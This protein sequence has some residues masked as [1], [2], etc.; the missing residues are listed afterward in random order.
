MEDIKNVDYMHAKRVCKNF[1]IRHFG[2]YHDLYL[3]SDIL[4][5]ADVFENFRKMCSKIY[6]LDSAKFLSAPRLTLKIQL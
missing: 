5:W 2:K 1:E 6:H 4:L 3:K